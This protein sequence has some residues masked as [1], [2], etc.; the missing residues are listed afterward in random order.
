MGS[1][2]Y[3]DTFIAVAPDSTAVAGME[4]GERAT[5]SVA[6]LTYRMISGHPYTYTSDD[7]QFTV[8]ADRRGIA[9]ADRAASR[10]QFFSKGQPCLR[11]SDLGKKFG[12]GI[13]HDGEGKVALYGVES[14]EYRQ[15]L[16]GERQ[17]SDGGPIPVKNAMRSS[18]S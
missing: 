18:R 16:T 14:E 8:F 3:Y 15:F 10:Q 11:A 12:W 9:D 6:A 1:T 13:H 4:P 7:V 17:T 5:P 2:N